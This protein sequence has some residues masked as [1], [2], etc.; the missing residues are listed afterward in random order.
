M[1]NV[2]AIRHLEFIKIAGQID[3]KPENI[4]QEALNMAIKALEQTDCEERQN[5]QCPFYTER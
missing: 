3:A 4:N 5:G 2:E 1:T